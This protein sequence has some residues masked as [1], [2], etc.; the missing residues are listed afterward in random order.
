[1]TGRPSTRS[2]TTTPLASSNPR[3]TRWPRGTQVYTRKVR[4]REGSHCRGRGGLDQHLQ[5]QDQGFR[6]ALVTTTQP[7]TTLATFTWLPAACS[8][9]SASSTPSISSRAASVSRSPISRKALL[10]G[11]SEFGVMCVASETCHAHPRLSGKSSRI[12]ATR[13]RS[14]SITNMDLNL[15]RAEDQTRGDQAGQDRPT[16]DQHAVQHRGHPRPYRTGSCWSGTRPA[17]ARP[18][19]C[20]RGARR[21]A[22]TD[23]PARLPRPTLSIPTTPWT[24]SR[25]RFWSWIEKSRGLWVRDSLGPWLHQVASRT[26]SCA[27]A[28]AARRRRVERTAAQSWRQRPSR[29]DDGIGSGWEQ[30]L[31]E[32]INRL[33]E[34]YRVAIVLC[35]LEGHTCEEAAR[36]IGRP[37]GTVKCWRARGRER[38]R[39]RLIRSG[40]TP[41]SA[42]GAAIGGD[43]ARATIEGTGSGGGRAGPCGL[44]DGRGGPGVSAGPGQRS[45]QGDDSE[46]A[47]DSE[48]P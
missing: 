19:N 32:E 11:R 40:L 43:A 31:H 42:L 14:G 48:R 34:R 25:P 30:A 22:R 41:S 4:I 38:L 8:G 35:D 3:H 16:A 33:P 12:V 47:E 44:S 5:W 9:P 18:R 27:L 10:L 17:R 46:Q 24:R 26:S 39:Q 21:A 7:S 6:H 28:A 1:M 45:V 37:V 36:R 13:A 29:H 2:F 23:G 15:L 20:L